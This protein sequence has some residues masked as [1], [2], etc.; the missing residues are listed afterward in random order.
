MELFEVVVHTPL[1]HLS[2]VENIAV[3]I[4][5]GGIYTE[6][7]SDMRQVCREITG[8]ELIDERLLALDADRAA[9]HIYFDPD[10]DYEEKTLQLRRLLDAAGVEYK[11]ETAEIAEDFWSE[12]WKAHYV[13]LHIGDRLVVRPCWR[14]YDAAEGEVVITLDPG[15]AFGTGT[16]ESTQLCLEMLEKYVTDGVSLLDVGAGSGILAIGGLLLGAAQADGC[17]IDPAAVK[18]S[19]ANAALNGLEQRICVVSGSVCD[20]P[21]KE[22]GIITANIVADIIIALLP[23]IIPR[24]AEGGRLI[25]GGIIAE[26]AEKV[27]AAAAEAGLCLADRKEKNGWVS[28]VFSLRAPAA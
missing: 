22:Y 27:A 9:V 18:M 7:Y 12:A 2:S 23:D 5:D 13:P 14:D 15:M 1:R 11:L 8:T 24:L 6:D 25:T 17:D 19:A 16:H 3:F 26:Y 28:L 4:A 20:T 21:R 10:A